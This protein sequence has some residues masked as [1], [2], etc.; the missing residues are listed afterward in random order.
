MCNAAC[1]DFASRAIQ[2]H[3]IRGKR[4]ID[5]GSYDVNGSFRHLVKS[6]QP[7]EWVGVDLAMCNHGHDPC[8]TMMLDATELLRRF[9]AE[10]FDFVMSSEM[11][12]HVQ[13][14]RFVIH[15]LKTVVKKGSPLV[16]TTRS[17]GFCYHCHPRDYWRFTGS[18]M[19]RIFSDF[20][21]EMLE[22]D[23]QEPGI[24]IKARKPDDYVEANLD[25]FK[26]LKIT[27]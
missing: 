22:S 7:R 8:V 1:L 12:E 20:S 27:P 16:I 5:V 26:V 6:F 2:D 9:G 15:N 19:E 10:S 13:D 18:D 17:P 24:F 11:L 25:G 4:V 14:W 23:Q 3:E 21:I